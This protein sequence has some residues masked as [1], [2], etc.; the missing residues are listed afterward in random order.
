V[1]DSN[2]GRAPDTIEA[3]GLDQPNTSLEQLLKSPFALQSYRWNNYS[4]FIDHTLEILFWSFASFP[5][6][7]RA[8]ALR[9]IPHD[10]FLSSILY[11]FHRRLKLLAHP[12]PDD[13]R[14][15]QYRH[16]MLLGPALVRHRVDDVWKLYEPE[17]GKYGGCPQM[18]WDCTIKVRS[19]FA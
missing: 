12:A 11:H 15:D 3:L 8:E 4:C 17:Q 10:S 5:S 9:S 16:E 19:A 13:S 18:W 2:D 1:F 7:L 14:R 6:E